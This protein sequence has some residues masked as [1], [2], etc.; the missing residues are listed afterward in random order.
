[1]VMSI[2]KSFC[3]YM[4]LTV[5]VIKKVT[6]VKYVEFISKFVLNVYV[7]VPFYIYY[8]NTKYLP[9]CKVNQLKFRIL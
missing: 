3:I 2:M 9:N 1:M 5:L 8:Y 4:H 7:C 6:L